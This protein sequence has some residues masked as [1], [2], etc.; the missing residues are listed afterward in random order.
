MKRFSKV[1]IEEIRKMDIEIKTLIL[2]RNEALTGLELFS[3]TS[4]IKEVEPMIYV[5]ESKFKTTETLNTKIRKNKRNPIVSVGETQVKPREIVSRED[6]ERPTFEM[7]K[8]G[9]HFKVSRLIMKEGRLVEGIPSLSI[10]NLLE[11]K[12]STQ[13]N[14]DGRRI[15]KRMIQ[16]GIAVQGKFL[17]PLGEGVKYFGQD[18]PQVSKFYINRFDALLDYI[19][20][21]LEL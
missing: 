11:E 7:H 17:V 4:D 18:S 3:N 15:I 19:G 12:G 16:R 9:R 13:P 5:S 10:R 1:V 14:K 20:L 2:E 8:N 6:N 21:D